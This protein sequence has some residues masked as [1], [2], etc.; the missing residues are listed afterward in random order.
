MPAKVEIT[1]MTLK[2]NSEHMLF[3]LRAN[4]IPLSV[5]CTLKEF[6][7]DKKKTL[8]KVNEN[9]RN[10]IRYIKLYKK[11]PKNPDKKKLAVW[12]QTDT[13]VSVRGNKM[14]VPE[15]QPFEL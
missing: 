5:S 6:Y 11:L 9:F 15:F 3:E 10:S 2:K 4:G 8:D 7:E 13:G 14:P 1:N 12:T